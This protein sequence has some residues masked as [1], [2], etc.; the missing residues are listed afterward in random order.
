MTKRGEYILAL[1]QALVGAIYDSVR[2]V[3]IKIDN[4]DILVRLYLDKIPDEDDDEE[5]SCIMAEFMS[6]FAHSEFETLKWECTFSTGRLNNL[7]D[8]DET[9]V[10]L[11][12]EALMG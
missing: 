6:S 7:K 8:P 9:F 4:Q 3:T 12:K 10:F 5:L 11:R 2:A 1:S